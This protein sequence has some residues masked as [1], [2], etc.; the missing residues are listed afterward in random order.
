ML[1]YFL[2]FNPPPLPPLTTQKIKILKKWKKHLEISPFY[3][4]FPRIM[5]RCYTASEIWRMTDVLF[6]FHFGL[7]FGILFLIFYPPLHPYTHP[8]KNPKNQD[9]KKMK[10]K[11][12]KRSSFDTR[13][14]KIMILWCR[15]PEIWCTM[16]R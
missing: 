13:V 4:T 8:A 11:Q 7:F 6:I 2:P 3:I 14:P 16:D 10:K 1:D 5:I 15:V 12:L 9:L